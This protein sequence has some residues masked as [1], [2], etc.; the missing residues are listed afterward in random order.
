[1]SEG[2]PGNYA[3]SHDGY[4]LTP[5]P[6]WWYYYQPIF[7]GAPQGTILAPGDYRCKEINWAAH[8]L[9]FGHRHPDYFA[10]RRPVQQ[11]T[12]E[13]HCCRDCCQCHCA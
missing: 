1:M 7:I 8:R 13:C 2:N 10:C 12:A 6:D 3:S 9:G 4:S 11:R 5:A